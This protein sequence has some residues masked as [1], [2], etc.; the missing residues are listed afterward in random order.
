MLQLGKPMMPIFYRVSPDIVNDVVMKKLW[1]EQEEIEQWEHA[2]GREVIYKEEEMQQGA[3]EDTS[4]WQAY[5]NAS[6][7]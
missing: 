1:D 4:Q 2:L 5:T 6:F 3:L 7:I